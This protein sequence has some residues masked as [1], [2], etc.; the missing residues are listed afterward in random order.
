MLRAKHDGIFAVRLAIPW[1]VSV[2]VAAAA[3]VFC[4]FLVPPLMSGTPALTRLGSW[5]MEGAPYLTIGLAAVGVFALLRELD[6]RRLRQTHTDLDSI[7]AMDWQNFELLVAEGFRR[8]GYAVENRGWY[9]PNSRVHISL[10]KDGERM[11][12]E[13]REWRASQVGLAPVRELHQTMAIEQADG[14]LLVTSG[15]FSADAEAFARDKPIGLIDGEALLELMERAQRDALRERQA[16]STPRCPVCERAMLQ[17]KA[18]RSSTIG[19]VY[20]RC[21]DLRCLGTRQV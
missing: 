15:S 8:L 14:A 9:V 1:W 3:Y 5:L 20:W 6:L 2:T 16:Q 19:Q 17:R 11:L 12:V 7:R 4:G 21:S 13:C 10:L 18:R